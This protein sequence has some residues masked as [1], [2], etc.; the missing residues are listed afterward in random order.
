MFSQSF[1]HELA[2]YKV[3]LSELISGSNNATFLLMACYLA[4][5]LLPNRG[6][7]RVPLL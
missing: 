4:L 7:A 1:T 6:S 3:F 5:I 2:N